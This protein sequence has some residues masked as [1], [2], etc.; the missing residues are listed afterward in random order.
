MGFGG[1]ITSLAVHVELEPCHI[2]SFPV[3]VNIECNA[4][5]HKSIDL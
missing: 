4:H 1:R 3:A 2:A 5:R